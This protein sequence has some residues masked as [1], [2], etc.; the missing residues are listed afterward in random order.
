M[1][2]SRADHTDGSGGVSDTAARGT[3]LGDVLGQIQ[4]A[5]QSDERVRLVGF[6]AFAVRWRAARPGRH[7]RT[8]QA[9][10]IP[11]RKMPTFRAGTRLRQAVQPP[12]PR[13]RRA[14]RSRLA[15]DVPSG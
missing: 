3:G 1:T 5:L 11:A 2:E 15:R 10:S 12:P 14:L 9:I 4:A 8:G 7:P 13:A 6:G